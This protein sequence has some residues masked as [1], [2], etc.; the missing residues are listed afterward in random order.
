MN[1]HSFT[2]KMKRSWYSTMRILRFE[3]GLERRCAPMVL[4][5]EV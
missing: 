1:I 3:R 5:G 4:A 2:K